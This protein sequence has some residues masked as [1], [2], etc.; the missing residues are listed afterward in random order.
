MP[1][2]MKKILP[3]LIS[4]LFIVNFSLAEPVLLQTA[5]T[6][7]KNFYFEKVNFFMDME[8]DDIIV[9]NYQT[10]F[11]GNELI[12]Y[13]FNFQDVGFVIISAD[14]S[15]FP[16]LGY[17]FE[18]NFTNETFPDAFSSW[19][20]HYSEQ[21]SKARLRNL[22]PTPQ[23]SKVW[24]NYLEF[25]PEQFQKSSDQKGVAPLLTSN[26]SQSYYY[27]I[28]CPND[29][30][31]YGGHTPAGC[32]AI[33]MAQLMFYFRYPDFGEGSH[34]YES[35]YGYEFADF[36]NTN[37]KWNE[38]VNA[39]YN[40]SNPAIAEL[41]YH[42]GVSVE[43]NYGTNSSSANTWDTQYALMNYFRYNENAQ[44]ISRFDTNV[45]FKDSLIKCLDQ[46]IPLIYKGGNFMESHSFVCDGYQDSSFFHFNWGWNGMYNGFFH[47]DTLNPNVWDFTF[48]QAAVINI[49]PE[50]NY[51]PFCLEK[52][53]LT[54]L[55]GTL[56]DGSGL[57]N[58]ENNNYCEWL[59]KPANP[60]I[61]NIQF[62]FT[63]FDTEANKDHV[64]I[65]DG[66]TTSDPVLGN[67]SGDQVP[68]QITSSGNELLI[69]FTSDEL[70]TAQGW[71]AEY[72]AYSEPFCNSLTVFNDTIAK[73]FSDKSGPYNYINNSECKWLIDPQ[74]YYYDSITSIHLHF[75]Y[76]EV[77]DDDTLFVFD[78]DSEEDI[79]LAGLTGYEI[80]APIQSLGNK[81]FL[82]F[83]TNEQNSADGWAA[84]YY[85]TLPVYC[86]DT[87]IFTDSTGTIDDGSGDKNYVNNADCY[88]LIKP[89]N[90][91]HITLTFTSFDLEYGFDQ[92]KIYDASEYPPV[93]I[94]T[95]WGHEI[96][97]PV[98][99]E[100][101]QMLVR[102]TS[103][104]AVV[105]DGW[106]AEYTCVEPGY[107]E[108]EF[109]YP[110]NIYP[111]PVKAVLNIEL[112]NE[113]T[114]GNYAIYNI[115]GKLCSTGDL[116][117]LTNVIDVEDFEKGVYFINVRTARFNIT[118][119]F[120][121]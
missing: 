2:Y 72:L 117:T 110:I 97:P 56:S 44:Y 66:G 81:L 36:A 46:K 26:W 65:Y 30:E 103:D 43:M 17:S 13:V 93:L 90:A 113:I 82:K 24:N 101:G 98:S 57:V 87:V 40:M 94:E 32:V 112:S 119:K 33:A 118:R 50:E 59:I 115:S 22:S 63:R 99:I 78:G 109:T 67:F 121:K 86:Q 88:W 60:D 107:F 105:F 9:D 37:Y 20:D 48:N 41:V 58:Y 120:V 54:V 100:S 7:A 111:N 80:P 3:S 74:E 89:E 83:K 70:N 47:I 104:Y 21:I 27:N 25:N 79:L 75:H 108:N 11:D 73:Y 68:E 64:I 8:Y 15:V 52:D 38:M 42:V 55:R 45:S 28:M 96:P 51:P 106:E 23:I 85:I 53:T 1:F 12:Y 6:L 71:S 102:F 34:G 19:M 91:Q 39:I 35:D 76:L 4:L 10:Y 62:W 95:F 5:K 18:E 77:A 29:P 31:S 116:I 14:D 61:T 92:V 49:Y 69:V 16:V 114:D 84:G